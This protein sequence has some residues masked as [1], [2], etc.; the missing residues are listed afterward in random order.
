MALVSTFYFSHKHLTYL[1]EP[2]KIVALP[3]HIILDDLCCCIEIEPRLDQCHII[4]SQLL[5]SLAVSAIEVL[6]LDKKTRRL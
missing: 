3:R 2:I 4:Q 1:V 5:G 6:L